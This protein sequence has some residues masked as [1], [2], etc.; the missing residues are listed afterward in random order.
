VGVVAERLAKTLMSPLFSVT[1]TL[2]SGE[3]WTEVG[4]TNPEKTTD[5]ENP[6][7]KVAA[8]TGLRIVPRRHVSA[9]PTMRSQDLMLWIMCISY[10]GSCASPTMADGTCDEMR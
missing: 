1:K 4:P 2:P 7:G 10:G 8:E 3:K 9:V 5:S 6:A